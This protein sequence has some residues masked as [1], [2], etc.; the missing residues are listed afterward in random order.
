MKPH[1]QNEHKQHTF[2][3]FCKQI[4]RNEKNDY[5]RELKQQGGHEV[6]FC[7]LPPHTLEQLAVW[8]KYFQD[9][10]LFEIMGFEVAVADE[11]LAEALKT[12]PQ[13]RLQII[14]LSYFG[15]MSDREIAERLNL[16]RRTVSHRRKSALRKLQKIME[17]YAD[18]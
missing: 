16:I 2:E 6:L 14:L 9:T 18:E 4:L 13:D 12:L 8:D 17:G 15:E 11:L 10:Y 1:S 7:E 3:H 5:H